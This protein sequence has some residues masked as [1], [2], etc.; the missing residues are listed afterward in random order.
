MM[1]IG[2]GIGRRELLI[3]GAATLAAATAGKAAGRAI[4]I[5]DT[6]IHLFD[7]NRPQGAP[8]RGPRNSPTYEKGAF[9]ADYAALVR[10]HDVVGA[11]EV[12]ASAWI[13]DNLWVLETAA[14][15]PI[16]IGTIGNI[17]LET[18]GFDKIVARFAKDPLFR[19]LRYGNL[20][21]Y[22][23]VTQS[24]EQSF[25]NGLKLLA[26]MDLVLDTANPRLDLLQAVVRISDAVPGLR[27]VLDHLP[28]FDPEPAD[29]AGYDAVL[30][31]LAQRPTVFAKLSEIIHP[32]AGRTATNVEAYRDRLRL[33][34]GTFGP[35]RVMFGSDWPNILQDTPLDQVFA[36]ARAFYADRPIAEQEKYFWRNSLAAYK[37]QPRTPAQRRLT[38]G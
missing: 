12:E 4:P 1:G 16:M 25:L 31:E 15:D 7:P 32:L 34:A 2:E 13:E 35:D 17:P 38:S 28:R 24:R 36:V 3:G 26:D 9:P 19:G 23:L 29:Q 30:R 21:G 6:H 8:Y 11:I 37:W 33:L 27:I 10:R 14:R 20:W 22:D 18:A 5:I